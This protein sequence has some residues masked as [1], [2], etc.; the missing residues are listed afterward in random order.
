MSQGEDRP[1]TTRR[2]LITGGAAGLAAVAGMT[3]GEAAPASAATP[4]PSITDWINVTNGSYTAYGDGKHDDSGVINQALAAAVP[5][6]VVYL[7]TAG[8]NAAG[9]T[10]TGTYLIYQPLVVPAG[11]CLRG[12]VAASDAA[13]GT[14]PDDYSAIIRVGG[15]AHWTPNA[16]VPNQ[17]AIVLTLPTNYTTNTLYRPAVESLWIDGSNLGAGTPVDGIAASGSVFHALIRNVG[18]LAASGNGIASYQ[19]HNASTG[20]YLRADGWEIDS[21]ILQ[22]C[23]GDG[24]N[25]FAE[26]SILRAVHAQGSG[27]D[28]IVIQHSNNRLIGCRADGSG[29]SGFTIDPMNSLMGSVTLIGCGTEGNTQNGLNVIQGNPGNPPGP[30]G[31]VIASGCSFDFDLVNGMCVAGQNIVT[32]HNCNVTAGTKPNTSNNGPTYALATASVTGVNPP[33]LVQAMGGFWNCYN[34]TGLVNDAA[35][36]SL[37]SYAAHGVFGGP[38]S[39]TSTIALHTKTPL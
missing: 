13:G 38:L 25:F 24:V 15:P 2:S 30:N 32:L 36:A 28:G 5:G 6:Q 14:T 10:I 8:T 29:G 7:P 21:C 19:F 20:K 22:S 37:I 1:S 26:D 17:G 35:P 11:V 9:G 27:G 34:T 12:P 39:G 33:M 4:P 23:L 16:N 31:M 18:V 3:L